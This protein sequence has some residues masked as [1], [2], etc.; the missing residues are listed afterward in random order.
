LF[1][2]EFDK[3][4]E[5]VGGKS[6]ETWCSPGQDSLDYNSQQPTRDDDLDKGWVI[7]ESE[8]WCRNAWYMNNYSAPD[9]GLSAAEQMAGI[10]ERVRSAFQK[11]LAEQGLVSSASPTEDI[12]FTTILLRSMS[13]FASVNAA[14]ASLFSKPNP[15]AR[16]TAACGD[17]L[18]A[19]ISVLVSLVIDR[20]QR[21]RRHGLHVQSRS[22]WAPANIGP[23]SQAISVPLRTDTAVE[24]DG[25]VL[26]VAGQ[27]PL[28]P[29][30]MDL[31]TPREAGNSKLHAFIFDAALSMQ[32]LWRIGRAMEVDWWLG[33]IAFLASGEDVS[34]QARIAAYMWNTMNTQHDADGEQ[35]EEGPALDAWDIKYGRQQDPSR[36]KT[37]ERRPLPNF[38]ILDAATA[39][40]RCPPPFFAVEVAELPRG[41]AIEWQALGARHQRITISHRNSG[42]VWVTHSKMRGFN[43]LIY[44]G[45][46]T[47]AEPGDLEMAAVN[48]VQNLT[49]KELAGSRCVPVSCVMYTRPRQWT[50]VIWKHQV[51]PCKSV[52]CSDGT[53]LVAGI[54]VHAR[55]WLP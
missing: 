28:V 46:L 12:V 37:V 47:V 41:A 50:G 53:E 42:D 45:M 34:S 36:N 38:S 15:P 35:E 18:P 54:V 5:D 49:T 31:A 22:Y 13:D 6:E 55:P 23:Y 40:S 44:I 25:S 27:I 32:H 52:R 29:A 17:S 43:S 33:G 1:D 21:D 26:Y 19:G 11:D 2:E 39:A 48:V 10:V 9:A 24:D 51:V 14:Y 20:G 7:R 16:V 3:L 4:V 8:S 30:T